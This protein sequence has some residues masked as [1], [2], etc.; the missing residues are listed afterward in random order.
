MTGVEEEA[1]SGTNQVQWRKSFGHIERCCTRI[2]TYEQ[3]ALKE[4]EWRDCPVF[5]RRYQDYIVENPQV[6]IGKE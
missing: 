4:R 2:G 1:I 5:N 3:S 6:T